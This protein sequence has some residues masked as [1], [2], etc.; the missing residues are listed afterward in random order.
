MAKPMEGYVYLSRLE[1][2]K[3]REFFRQHRYEIPDMDRGDSVGG[4]PFVRGLEEHRKTGRL[5][6]PRQMTQRELKYKVVR[7]AGFTNRRWKIWSLHCEGNSQ[8]RIAAKL[9]INRSTVCMA[10]KNIKS[11][12]MAARK[13]ARKA[14]AWS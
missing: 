6:I 11:K 13:R 7:A 10:L 3:A 4:Q 12:I 1:E 8:C 9:D 14:V 5:V 2:R